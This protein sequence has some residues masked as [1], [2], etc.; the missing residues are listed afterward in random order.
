MEPVLAVEEVTKVYHSLGTLFGRGGS[1]V[2]AVQGVSLRIASGEA[3]G[4]VG[5]SG[6]GKSTL[7]R[8]ILALERPTSGAISLSGSDTHRLRGPALRTLRRDVQP[9][10]QNPYTAL[11]PM[12]TIGES[13][14]EPL[15]NFT[16]MSQTERA[17]RVRQLLQEV[18]LPE[19][20]IDAYPYALSGGERQRACI[21]RALALRPKLLICDEPVSSLDKSIQAQI[22]NLFRRL[23]RE[24][25]LTLLFISHDLAVVNYLCDQVAVMLRGKIVEVGRREEVLFNPAHPYTRS[26]LASA[27]FFL[28]GIPL[29]NDPSGSDLVP[30]TGCSFQNRCP[31]VDPLCRKEPP[32]LRVIGEGH[33]AACHFSESIFPRLKGREID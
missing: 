23:R 28:E 29:R 8:M 17:D 32:L 18:G 16:S 15:L 31:H 4:L 21:A 11:N 9:V 13:V 19:R 27:S 14:E 22:L 24:H 3:V 12:R 6:S 30:L 33:Q 5:E 2:A 1:R 7:I 26:L 25:G 20:M 10:F